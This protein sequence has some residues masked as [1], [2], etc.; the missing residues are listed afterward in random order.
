MVEKVMQ[1][2]RVPT[3]KV[4]EMRSKGLSN[5]Q[6]IQIL[7]RE[8]HDMPLIFNAMNQADIKSGID[9]GQL[10]P[11]GFQSQQSGGSTMEQEP[12]QQGDLPES[13]IQQPM[14]AETVPENIEPVKVAT[15]ESLTATV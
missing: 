3:D 8:G 7:Q 9:Y 14:G 1:G 2:P 11:E 4:M 15:I 5:N 10:A 13:P 6:I 12:I